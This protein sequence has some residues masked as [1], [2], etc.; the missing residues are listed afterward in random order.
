MFTPPQALETVRQE[1]ETVKEQLADLIETI[2]NRKGKTHSDT[3][4]VVCNFLN[5]LPGPG[6]ECVCEC[7]CV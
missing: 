5:N 3:I 7:V 6:G 1:Y 4:A 2:D